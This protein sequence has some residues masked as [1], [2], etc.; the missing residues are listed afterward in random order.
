MLVTNKTFTR[1]RLIGVAVALTLGCVAFVYGLRWLESM[2]TFRPARITAP[3]LKSIAE[4]AESVWFNSADG[5]RLNGWYFKSQ[6]KPET[7]TI[8]FFDGNGGNVTNVGWMGQRFAKHGFNVLLFD[9]R[10]YGASEGTCER[11]ADLYADGDAAVNFL[12]S[13]KRIRP[14]QMVLYGQS[15]GTAVVADVASHN[16]YRRIAQAF[17]V[18]K[19][20]EEAIDRPWRWSCCFRRWGR[21]ISESGRAVCSRSHDYG[22]IVNVAAGVIVSPDT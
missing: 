12:I 22:T 18:G 17:R 1:E 10:G 11:E 2:M 14:E 7:G 20:A 8:V 16:S 13:E 5:T 19:R 15:L 9:Y 4:G 3:E 21:T 6:I